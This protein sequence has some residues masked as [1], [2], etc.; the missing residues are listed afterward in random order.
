MGPMFGKYRG[1]V[2]GHEPLPE[3]GRVQVTVPTVLGEAVVWAMPCVP[4]AGKQ[5]GWFL[6][7]PVGSGVWV[8][9]EA[10]NT[11]LP[12]WSG[13]FWADGELPAEATSSSILVF[14]TATPL[15]IIDKDGK[16]ETR[17]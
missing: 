15:S 9:F 7:P 3:L 14:K 17:T 4:Y 2:R 11:G 16:P 1:L 12:I 10:G 6:M 13:C 8:E 5:L